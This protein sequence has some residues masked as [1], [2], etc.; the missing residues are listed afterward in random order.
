MESMTEWIEGVCDEVLQVNDGGDMTLA[1]SL[2]AR[3][4]RTVTA[5]PSRGL[6]VNFALQTYHPRNVLA[7]QADDE[8]CIEIFSCV[9]VD[10]FFYAGSDAPEAPEGWTEAPS[11]H[12]ML[13]ERRDHS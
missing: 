10:R 7:I 13:Y 8:T 1:D 2:A 6:D 3:G 12:G 5:D 4:V 11:V 9:C